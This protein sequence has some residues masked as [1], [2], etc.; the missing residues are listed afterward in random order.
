MGTKEAA[1]FVLLW[2][3][4]VLRWDAVQGGLPELRIPSHHALITPGISSYSSGAWIKRVGTAFEIAF[5]TLQNI[6]LLISHSA[7]E[8]GGSRPPFMEKF[9]LHELVKIKGPS[10]V[11]VK[12]WQS[13]SSSPTH[14]KHN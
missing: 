4:I 10:Q 5:K 7:L 12:N 8:V 13:W 3:L 2:E 11:R 9:L 14:L 6:S 1:W